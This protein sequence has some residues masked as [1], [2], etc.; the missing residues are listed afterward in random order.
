M[1]HVQRRNARDYSPQ[2]MEALGEIGSHVAADMSEIRALY[3]A[4]AT[5]CSQPLASLAGVH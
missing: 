5:C 1:D 3:S 4:L 2:N